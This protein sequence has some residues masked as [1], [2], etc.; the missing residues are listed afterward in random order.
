MAKKYRWNNWKEKL[1]GTI[2]LPEIN[3]DAEN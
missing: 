1:F 3:K 2:S